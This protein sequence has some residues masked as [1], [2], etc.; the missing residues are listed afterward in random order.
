MRRPRAPDLAAA[1]VAAASAAL[2][3]ATVRSVTDDAFWQLAYGRQLVHTGTL[4][5]VDTYSWT[6]AGHPLVVTEWAF[7]ALMYLASA[8]GPWAAWSLAATTIAVLGLCALALYWRLCGNRATAGLLALGLLVLCLPFLQLLPQLASF[9]LFAAVWLVLEIGRTRWRP[10][11]LW[12]LPLLLMLWANM[13]GTFYFGLALLGLDAVL[14]LLGPRLPRALR[15]RYTPQARRTLLWLVPVCAAVTLL[16]PY[17]PRLYPPEVALAFSSFHFRYIAEFQSPDFHQPF[18]HYAVLPALLLAL[19]LPL[20]RRRRLPARDC[21]VG[22]ALLGGSLIMV[23]VLPYALVALGA[24]CAASLRTRRRPVRPAL[25]WQWG[26]VAAALAALLLHEPPPAWPPT[27]GEPVAAARYVAGHLG[28]RG[29]NTYSWG[30]YLLWAWRGHPSVFIDSRG[31]LYMETW[32]AQTY[33]E[34]RQLQVDPG[35]TLRALGVRWALL[36]LQSPLARV[37][38]LQGWSAV[39]TGGPAVVLVPPAGPA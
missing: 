3:T 6:A 5:A 20:L 38:R 35:K 37:L 33:V 24:V 8:A 23:R 30:S 2:A 27:A 13:H 17:G 28:G 31:D 25:W 19:G 10:R 16:T 9:A 4:P 18:L 39:Y 32:V 14:A 15:A 29:F 11:I 34:V 7:D 12:L 36:P 26:V 22:L 1:A 21:L